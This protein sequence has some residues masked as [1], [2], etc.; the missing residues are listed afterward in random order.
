MLC[1]ML[2]GGTIVLMPAF[3]PAGL[4]ETIARHRV[5]HGGFVP[6]QLQRLMELPE[7]RA[8]RLLVAAGHHVLRLAAATCAEARNA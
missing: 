1:T 6:V 2:A 8:A 7:L 3:T 4:A 5:T